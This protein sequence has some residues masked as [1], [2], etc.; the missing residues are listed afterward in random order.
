MPGSSV[1]LTLHRGFDMLSADDTGVRGSHHSPP[2]P[3][4]GG[5]RLGETLEGAFAWAP[6]ADYT[7][8][9]T[10][11]SATTGHATVRIECLWSGS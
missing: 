7:L 11:P 1:A 3:V 9:G 2:L 5:R 6:M 4:P 8:P 10:R